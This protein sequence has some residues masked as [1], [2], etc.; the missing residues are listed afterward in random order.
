MNTE[1]GI[2]S[3]TRKSRKFVV[4]IVRNIREQR[5]YDMQ[6]EHPNIIKSEKVIHTSDWYLVILPELA[7]LNLAL[8]PN[9]SAVCKLQDM[10]YAWPTVSSFCTIQGLRI[11]MSNPVI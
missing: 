9:S 2:L 11:W 5:F 6:V 4:K 7:S 8:D 1:G 10:S 3:A